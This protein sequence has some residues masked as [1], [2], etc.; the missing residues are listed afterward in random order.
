MSLIVSMSQ[1]AEI[2]SGSAS[3]P[4]ASYAEHFDRVTAIALSDETT[5]FTVASTALGTFRMPYDMNLTRVK[6]SLTVTGSTD[7]VLDVNVSGSSILSTKLTIDSGDLT[8]KGASTP[9]VIEPD[10]SSLSDDDEISVD[11]DAVGSGSA[12]LKIYLIGN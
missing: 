4:S 10:S 5:E 1:L 7:M 9:Y 8:S 3:V 2:I 11:I 12:G 6:A